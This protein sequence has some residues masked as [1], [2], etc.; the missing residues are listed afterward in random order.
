M[1]PNDSGVGIRISEEYLNRCALRIDISGLRFLGDAPPINNLDSRIEDASKGIGRQALLSSPVSFMWGPDECEN[2]N[3]VRLA[4]IAASPCLHA[5]VRGRVNPFKVFPELS[6]R[7][8]LSLRKAMNCVG[9]AAISGFRT[10][11]TSAHIRSVWIDWTRQ[12]H[13]P[14][15]E[16]EL[17]RWRSHNSGTPVTL[18]ND[19]DTRRRS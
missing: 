15:R 6:V 10:G 16:M 1:V 9:E 13:F 12:G 8:K 17:F 2:V 19:C 14:R 11:R 4:S 5:E 3:V 18:R 7:C